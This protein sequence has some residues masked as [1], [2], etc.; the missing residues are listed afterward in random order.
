MK[1]RLIVLPG[2]EGAVQLLPQGLDL[3]PLPHLA[4]DLFQL[5]ESRLFGSVSGKLADKPLRRFRRAS[6]NKDNIVLNGL[7]KKTLGCVSGV[8]YPPG[9][10]SFKRAAN[11]LTSAISASSPYL[12]FRL[13][14][15]KLFEAA[16]SPVQPPVV[17]STAFNTTYRRHSTKNNS[18]N[19]NI[20]LSGVV[21]FPGLNAPA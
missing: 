9:L 19:K 21:H 16:Y 14:R 2:G 12:K 11:R 8:G 17:S 6:N 10:L 13:R 5:L 7:P 18:L 15:T 3:R 1:P 4:Q 20:F